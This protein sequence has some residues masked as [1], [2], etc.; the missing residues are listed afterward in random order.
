LSAHGTWGWAIGIDI[1]ADLV[2]DDAPFEPQVELKAG[3]AATLCFTTQAIQCGLRAELQDLCVAVHDRCGNL[4]SGVAAGTEV[5]LEPT[6]ACQQPGVAAAKLD[7][8]AGSASG[9]A[10]KQRLVDGTA[11]FAG[12]RVKAKHEGVYTARAVCS[13]RKLA[14]EPALLQ[15]TVTL[16]NAITSVE[17]SVSCVPSSRA[18]VPQCPVATASV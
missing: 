2:G 17:L 9:G 3:R 1:E 11:T 13:S 8:P 14:L 7:T 18:A 15:L 12:V 5:T 10:I 16:S 6:A 4:A